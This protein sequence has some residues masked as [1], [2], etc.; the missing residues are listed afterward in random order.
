MKPIVYLG[1]QL[2]PD[3][4]HDLFAPENSDGFN[5][6]YTLKGKKVRAQNI[7]EFHFM[8][9]PM[10]PNME[11]RVAFESDI[12]CTGYWNFIKDVD[13]IVI[14]LSNKDYDSYFVNL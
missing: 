1:E 9:P 8:F 10:F 6:S 11:N 13:D 14:T 3:Q 2:S 4:E 12:H 7:T 5:I